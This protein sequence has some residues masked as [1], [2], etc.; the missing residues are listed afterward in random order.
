ML[1]ITTPTLTPS[2]VKTSLKLSGVEN[3]RNYDLCK[4]LHRVHALAANKQYISLSIFEVGVYD[5]TSFGICSLSLFF[6]ADLELCFSVIIFPYAKP[7]HTTILVINK[8][9]EEHFCF[10]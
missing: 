3:K 10:Y 1:L 5:V 6:I 2:R 7:Y 4:D 8:P 9:K